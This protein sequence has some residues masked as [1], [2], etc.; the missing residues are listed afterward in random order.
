MKHILF[1]VSLYK[2]EE[3]TGRR[4]SEREVFS[5]IYMYHTRTVDSIN[6][7]DTTHN[8]NIALIEKCFGNNKN[9]YC[10]TVEYI[11]Q[12]LVT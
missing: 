6:A 3:S 4:A 2:G 7:T 1:R 8:T 5:T 12:V 11:H 10:F 9:S